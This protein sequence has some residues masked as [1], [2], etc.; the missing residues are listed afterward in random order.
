MVTAPWPQRSARAQ[1]PTASR[2]VNL[3]HYLS[4]VGTVQFGLDFFRADDL[5]DASLTYLVKSIRFPAL[6]F[7]I[8]YDPPGQFARSQSDHRAGG[9]VYG[10][11][12]VVVWSCDRAAG[13]H[14][15]LAS[16]LARDWQMADGNGNRDRRRRSIS[17]AQSRR[18][19]ASSLSSSLASDDDLGIALQNSI[20]EQ[21]GA[22][23][24]FGEQ[25]RTFHPPREMFWAGV[26]VLSATN[27][28]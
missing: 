23:N 20:R 14:G 1:S 6:R 11:R 12:A 3:A 5:E 7:Q 15:Q 13:L 21:G 18:S 24:F 28:A 17:S 19:N 22:V 25:C 2:A 26:L 9:H 10:N 16:R 8:A 27:E 4:G